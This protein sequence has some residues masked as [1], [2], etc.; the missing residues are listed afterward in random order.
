M[1]GK[2]RRWEGEGVVGGGMER[3]SEG[4]GRGAVACGTPSAS[5]VCH[6]LRSVLR[7]LRSSTLRRHPFPL[8]N[9]RSGMV[10]RP[11]SFTGAL[12]GA[13]APT[14]ERS[15]CHPGDRGR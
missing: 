14:F 1:T 3:R 4:W 15:E 11:S 7:S 9:D 5:E 8:P 2:G 6:T 13:S 10:G 12:M